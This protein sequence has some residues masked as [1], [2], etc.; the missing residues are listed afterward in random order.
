M[1]HSPAE[2]AAVPIA[3]ISGV[4]TNPHA[5]PFA[6]STPDGLA[7]VCSASNPAEAE[8]MRQ[9]LID[10]GYHAEYVP[11]VTTGAFGTSG[12]AHMYVQASEKDEVREFL[13]QLQDSA[14]DQGDGNTDVD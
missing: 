13:R 8:L 5:V 1:T 2:K 12:S 7:H 6:T 14:P 11:S 9:T 10:A 3:L 4:P